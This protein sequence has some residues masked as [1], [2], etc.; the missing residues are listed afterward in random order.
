MSCASSPFPFQQSGGGGAGAVTSVFGRVGAVV[1]DVADYAGLYVRIA[2]AD[3]ITARH[4]FNNAGG[5]FLVTGAAAGVLVAGLNADQLD[6]IDSTGFALASHVHSAAD[7]TS[8]KLALARG[9]TNLDASATGGAS[10]V[11]RQNSA[12]GAFTVSQLA[13]SELSFTDITTND[14]ST[15]KHGFL[16]KLSNVATQYMDGTGAWSTPAGG[17]TLDGCRVHMTSN[18]SINNAT[19]TTLSFTTEN[20]DNG[21]LHSNVTNPSRITVGTTAIYAIAAGAFF[22]QGA[23]LSDRILYLYV[24]GTEICEVRT[25]NGGTALATGYTAV[26]LADVLNL[27]AGDY[28]EL[29][30]YQ[31]SGGALNVLA[32]NVTYLAVQKVTA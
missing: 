16:K 26:S 32:G 23:D 6:G 2:T 19:V 11:V 31:G 30:V 27:T 10:Q 12:G 18:Q 9:G 21:G 1:A 20:F 24:N 28:V 8:G 17:G 25:S 29:K 13:E 4:T 7:I 22:D 15:T 14:A 5:P 3:T